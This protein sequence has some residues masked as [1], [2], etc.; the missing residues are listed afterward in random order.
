MQLFNKAHAVP[1]SQRVCYW[2]TLTAICADL[3]LT[4]FSVSNLHF[5]L[6]SVLRLTARLA[7]DTGRP[8]VRLPTG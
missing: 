8:L 4:A 7:G 2:D 3:E 5:L 1:L 6:L